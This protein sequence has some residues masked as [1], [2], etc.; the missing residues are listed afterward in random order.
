MSKAWNDF[1][2]WVL[3]FT[4]GV[5]FSMARAEIRSAAID[6]CEESLCWREDLDDVSVL[7]AVTEHALDPP[8]NATAI[9]ALETVTPSTSSKAWT[10]GTHY[11]FDAISGLLTLTVS[12]G[13][14]YTLEIVAAVK[15]SRTSA[16]IKDSI[17]EN[18]VDGI[19]AKAI[20]RL[21]QIPGKQWSNPALA[22]EYEERFLE[23]AGKA[24]RK[25]Q[26]QYTR[27]NSRVAW[28]TF[29]Q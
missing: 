29:G 27:G 6:F 18:F 24:K 22:M 3:P 7:A 23:E 26:K 10:A 9:A 12:P 17:F 11:T 8:D 19:A 4:P 2:P 5:P 25:Q 14:A 13:S 16:T 15:P 28:R 21:L 1:F 20:Q